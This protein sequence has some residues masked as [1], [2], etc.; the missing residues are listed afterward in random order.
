MAIYGAVGFRAN[1]LRMEEGELV[2]SS[3]YMS[4]F[5]WPQQ[6]TWARCNSCPKDNDGH[7]ISGKTC[8]CGIYS[9]KSIP[10]LSHYVRGDNYVPILIEALGYYWFHWNDNH[11]VEGLTSA[12]AQVIGVIS[13]FSNN[14]VS[15][16]LLWKQALADYY[17]VPL[18]GLESAQEL[19][20]WA[21]TQFMPKEDDNEP[22]DPSL[23]FRVLES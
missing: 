23:L 5:E 1:M 7:I 10:V 21:W 12:G 13:D 9:T 20:E 14:R 18:I 16:P 6:V 11:T 4:H 8:N 3:P 22:A 17:G 15:Y 2:I 19:I